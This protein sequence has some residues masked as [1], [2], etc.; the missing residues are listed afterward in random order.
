MAG[1]FLAIVEASLLIRFSHQAGEGLLYRCC[2][3]LYDV[4]RIS[5]EVSPDGEA[6]S[7]L[8]R[9]Q[10]PTTARRVYPK[11]ARSGLPRPWACSG[12]KGSPFEAIIA[13]PTAPQDDPFCATAKCRH[14][15]LAAACCP[16]CASIGMDGEAQLEETTPQLAETVNNTTGPSEHN[17]TAE[18]ATPTNSS[19]C[20]QVDER[21]ARALRSPA[22]EGLP[23]LEGDGAWQK[24]MLAKL[25][26]Q[27]ERCDVKRDLEGSAQPPRGSA[28]KS[29]GNNCPFCRD[30]GT[31]AR[32]TAVQILDGSGADIEADTRNQM[33]PSYHECI[34]DTARK[35]CGADLSVFVATTKLEEVNKGTGCLGPH[36]AIG[37]ELPRPSGYN[38][39]S[40]SGSPS[41]EAQTKHTVRNRDIGAEIHDD[42]N[43]PSLVSGS[44]D[45]QGDVQHIASP[46]FLDIDLEDMSQDTDV[47]FPMLS[48][49][50]SFI[51]LEASDVDL[52]SAGGG[53]GNHASPSKISNTELP[54]FAEYLEDVGV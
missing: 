31:K 37:V 3:K 46:S 29:T 28:A 20:H 11:M 18:R 19:H 47:E 54:T 17:E 50:V 42:G 10:Q 12:A 2:F 51:E 39:N 53:Y 24:P 13:S 33:L 14:G 30:I 52:S 23:G 6:G 43:M 22:T 21:T 49:S 36:L 8:W 48:S 15:A 7:V 32:D 44:R 4:A 34:G 41:M 26:P 16:S 27:D 45:V 38:V 25:W 40:G 35:R 1:C 9:T 5:N